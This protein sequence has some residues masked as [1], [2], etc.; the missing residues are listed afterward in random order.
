MSD[1]KELLLKEIPIKKQ[2]I[3]GTGHISIEILGMFYWNRGGKQ[4]VGWFSSKEWK[5]KVDYSKSYFNI[6]V[7]EA[8]YYQLAEDIF[9]QNWVNQVKWSGDFLDCLAC[10]G[11]DKV[12][13]LIKKE[14]V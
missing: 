12:K 7:E 14:G 3:D 2:G 4:F 11:E 6:I 9:K 8:K 1:L 10:L 13:E 5:N